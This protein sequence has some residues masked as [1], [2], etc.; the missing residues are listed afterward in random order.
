MIERGVRGINLKTHFPSFLLFELPLESTEKNEKLGILRGKK[1]LSVIEFLG[2]C[3][4][5]KR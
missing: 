4:E 1:T 2:L 5:Q 3:P